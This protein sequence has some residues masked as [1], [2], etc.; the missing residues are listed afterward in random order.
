MQYIIADGSWNCL[1]SGFVRWK[2]ES[3]LASILFTSIIYK[4]LSLSLHEIIVFKSKCFYCWAMIKISFHICLRWYKGEIGF[5]YTFQLQKC[6][7]QKKN[8]ISERYNEKQFTFFYCILHL[9]IVLCRILEGSINIP[10]IRFRFNVFWD[11]LEHIRDEE[12]LER[13]FRY[14][15]SIRTQNSR[16]CE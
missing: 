12:W 2:N 9:F 8:V 1:D 6:L 16:R 5:L 15:V 10:I 11:S 13:K 14:C 3:L 7:L 4:H